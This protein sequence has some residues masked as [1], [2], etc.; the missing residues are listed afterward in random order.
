MI[1]PRMADGVVGV[2]VGVSAGPGVPGTAGRVLVVEDDAG[3]SAL[4]TLLLEGDGYQVVCRDSAF[5]L[6]AL[7][8]RWRPD[9]VL[10]DL[11]LPYRCGAAVLADLKGHPAT[12]A[13]PVVVVSGAPEALPRA[14][15]ALAAAVL[16]KPIPMQT[17]LAKVRAALRGGE[18]PGPVPAAR[19]AAA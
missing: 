11:G 15:A 19:R 17:L 7:L 2:G 5:G 3:I 8:R 14:R 13:I 9:V 18:P 1:E 6:A 4:W 12:A 10:L 16:T